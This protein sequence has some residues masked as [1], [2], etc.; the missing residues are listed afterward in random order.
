MLS[1]TH[2]VN[3]KSNNVDKQNYSPNMISIKKMHEWVFE[4]R[5]DLSFMF[6]DYRDTGDEPEVISMT[7]PIPIEHLSWDC[8]SI[9]AQGYGVIQM[10]R[11]LKIVESQTKSQFYKGF[12]KAYAKYLQKEKKKHENFAKRF[13]NPDTIDW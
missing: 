2:A 10:C 5:K 7:E 11:D 12:L 13:I 4:E 1:D 9:E 8:L 6:V 3:V